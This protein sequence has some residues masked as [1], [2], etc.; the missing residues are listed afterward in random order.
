LSV[1]SGSRLP[2]AA[3]G[4]R[5]AAGGWHALGLKLGLRP[6]P[7]AGGGTGAGTADAWAEAAGAL[8]VAYQKDLDRDSAI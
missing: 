2:R 5:L 3:G 8:V 4:W 7:A 6:A 1:P